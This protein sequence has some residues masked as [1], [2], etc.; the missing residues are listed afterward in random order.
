MLAVLLFCFVC[1]IFLQKVGFDISCKLSPRRQSSFASNI[2]AYFLLKRI[3]KYFK[4]FF[5]EIFIEHYEHERM[6]DI[7]I[8]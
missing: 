3:R 2:K 1:F 7:Y 5:A 4:L 8:I 6:K